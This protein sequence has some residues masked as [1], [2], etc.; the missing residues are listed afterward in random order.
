MTSV[1]TT[2]PLSI[3]QRQCMDDERTIPGVFTSS[4]FTMNAVAELHGRL[5]V[6]ALGRALNELLRR[7]E[8]LRTRFLPDVQVVAPQVDGQIVLVDGVDIHTPVENDSPTPMVVTLARPGTNEHL[9]SLHLHHL[10]AD[11]Q[12]LWAALAELGALYGAELGGPAVPPPTAQFGEYVT[13]EL[14]QERTGLPAAREWWQQS[15]GDKRFARVHPDPDSVTFDFRD[16]LLSAKEFAALEQLGRRQR[17]TVLTT[18]MAAL[19]CAMRPHITGDDV[20]YS[21]VFRTRDRPQWQRMFGPCFA[22]TYLPLPA[23]PRGLTADYARAVRDT[24]LKCQRHNR[25]DVPELRSLTPDMAFGA[26]VSTFFEFIPADRPTEVAFG[27]VAARVVTAAG[28][29]ANG[30]SRLGIRSRS[31]VDGALV[32]AVEA[33]GG[34]W[35]ESTARQLWRDVAEMVRGE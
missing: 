27:P 19:T 32:G 10:A 29:K 15:L 22:I 17:G 30:V 31:T 1:E 12:T 7:H 28:P 26:G 14:E 23:P 2:W 11:P 35:P 3:W 18:M 13:A 5:D 21:T 4:T 9:L 8:I 24:I 33:R 6:G 34:G 20:L 25:F 16:E